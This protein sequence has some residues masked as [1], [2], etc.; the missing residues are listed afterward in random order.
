MTQ[1]KQ[2]KHTPDEWEVDINGDEICVLNRTGGDKQTGEVVAVTYASEGAWTWSKERALGNARRIVKAVNS[3][4]ELLEAFDVEMLL[5][6]AN[7]LDSFKDS[8]RAHS[9]RV[10]AERQQR[11]IIKAGGDQ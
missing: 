1:T 6:I 5:T 9:L 2:A 4:E 8:A 11:A 10:L 3:H 7:E